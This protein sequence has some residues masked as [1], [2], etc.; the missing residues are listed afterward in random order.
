MGISMGEIG[1]KKLACFSFGVSGWA[2]ARIQIL[3]FEFTNQGKRGGGNDGYVDICLRLRIPLYF[4]RP[5]LLVSGTRH[6]RSYPG[7]T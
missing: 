6:R 5:P 1:G 3:V 7:V 2:W 4:V